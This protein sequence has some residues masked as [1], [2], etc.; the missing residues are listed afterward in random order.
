MKLEDML[1]IALSIP[2]Q[3]YKPRKNRTPCASAIAKLS[4]FT[5]GKCFLPPSLA[6]LGS[7]SYIFMHQESTADMSLQSSPSEMFSGK[8]IYLHCL[9]FVVST[10]LFIS[11]SPHEGRLSASN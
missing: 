1:A 6:L 9:I 11:L 4:T 8:S 7:A 2:R 10:L 3:E 5:P